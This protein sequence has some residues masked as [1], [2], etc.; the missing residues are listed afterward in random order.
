MQSNKAIKFWADDDKPREKMIHKGPQALSD[1]ELIGILLSTGSRE[2]SAVD[3]GREIMQLADNKLNKLSKFTISQIQQIKG[4]GEAKAVTIVAAME[5]GRRRQSASDEEMHKVTSSRSVAEFL[6]P[7]MQDLEVEKFCVVYLNNSNKLI[8][9]EFISHGGQTA[10]VVDIKIILRNAV[11]RLAK[12]IIVAHNHP[13][14][15]TSPSP[16][17]RQLTEKL[18]N[19]AVVMDVELVDHIIVAGKQYVSFADEGWL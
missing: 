18:K 19:A 16:Q 2:K 10:T 6:I 12:K 7:L 9:H 17:D 5:L 4:I 15:N 13:S 3:L 8:G 14:G 1:A 11:L